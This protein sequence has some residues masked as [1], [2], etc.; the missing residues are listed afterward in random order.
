MHGLFRQAVIDR[1]SAQWLGRIVL[2]RPLSF[3]AYALA[4]T[5]T[6][7]AVVLFLMFGQYTRRTQVSGIL[8]PE[9]GVM[10]LVSPVSGT[11]TEAKATE[12]ASVRYSERLMVLSTERASQFEART[13]S[14][15][16]DKMAERKVSLKS[17]LEKAKTL[18]EQQRAMMA[19]RSAGLRDEL[20]QLDDEIE[21]QGRRTA[22]ADTQRDKFQSLHSQKFVSELQLHQKNDELYEQQ[23]KLKSLA[24]MRHA[25]SREL[26]Q[27][28][29]EI[30]GIPVKLAREQAST[31]RG[32]S[33]LEQDQMDNEAKRS[34]AINAPQAGTVAAI[35]HKIGSHVKAGDILMTI[36][37]S[38]ARLEAHFFAPSKAIGFVA[39]GQPVQ[40]RYHAYPHEKFGKYHGKVV[41]ISRVPLQPSEIPSAIPGTTGVAEA[42][43][44]ITVAPDSQTAVAFGQSQNLQ[45]GMLVDGA[46]GQ[47]TRT[48]LDWIL[49]P[50][51]SLK[52]RL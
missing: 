8:V 40:L 47:D 19:A 51:Y 36:V 46:I 49:E 18:A 13:E 43:Y 3:G 31:Q 12:G 48:L 24:R 30:Q 14:V 1:A 11:V 45:V 39:V 21:L 23:S 32:I 35:L 41:G 34:I 5:L 33:V 28:E 20:R 42:L 10:R 17:E 22:S 52:G 4:A 37:P 2:V 50:L 7:I 25:I 16:A 6:I 9:F 44:R 27:V 26:S 29:S 15:I 38:D